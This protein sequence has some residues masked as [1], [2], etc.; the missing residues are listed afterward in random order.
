M[1]KR[2]AHAWSAFLPALCLAQRK[3]YRYLKI[4]LKSEC[5]RTPAG[6]PQFVRPPA[7]LTQESMLDY[8]CGRAS[9]P[10]ANLLNV[11][12]HFQV[13]VAEPLEAS[14][15]LWPIS[16]PSDTHCCDA[17]GPA[18]PGSTARRQPGFTARGEGSLTHGGSLSRAQEH[19]RNGKEL[20]RAAKSRWQDPRLQPCLARPLGRHQE[21]NVAPE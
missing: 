7:S 21:N 18:R 17:Q 4:F 11:G 14:R 8:Q 16:L 2:L 20:P 1:H 3:Y 19:Q 13:L 5:V 6:K 12:N 15:S 10:A 9:F